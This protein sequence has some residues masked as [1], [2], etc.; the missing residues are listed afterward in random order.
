[1]YVC[2]IY[3]TGMRYYVGR[4]LASPVE[5]FAYNIVGRS[6]KVQVVYGCVTRGLQVPRS[7]RKPKKRLEVV[8]WAL[9]CRG[10][11]DRSVSCYLMRLGTRLVCF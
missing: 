11:L 5:S 8:G 7:G 10:M 9:R 2:A 6:D 4:W 3:Q 1:M